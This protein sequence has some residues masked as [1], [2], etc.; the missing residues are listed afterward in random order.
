MSI[1]FYHRNLKVMFKNNFSEE[2]DDLSYFRNIGGKLILEGFRN[3]RDLKTQ[4]KIYQTYISFVQNK[5]LYKINEE[6]RDYYIACIL[7]LWKLNVYD[8]DDATSPLF[9]APK[10]KKKSVNNLA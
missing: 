10:R 6:E 9:I 4:I 3:K 7:A 2:E 5:K 1:Y 8:P